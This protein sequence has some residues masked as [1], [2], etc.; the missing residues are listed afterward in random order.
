MKCF[1]MT[2]NGVL[3]SYGTANA[4]WAGYRN[5][6]SMPTASA[7]IGLLGCALGIPKH[8][9]AL[10][11]L[12]DKIVIYY[13]SAPD[14]GQKDQQNNAIDQPVGSDES[15][16]E[17]KIAVPYKLHDYQ[18]ISPRRLGGFGKAKEPDYF[19][20]ANGTKGEQLPIIK[21]YL[22]NSEFTLY[23]A[24]DDS[25][26]RTIHAALLDPKWM[27]YLGR[28]CCIPASPLVCKNLELIDVEDIIGECQCI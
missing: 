18:I 5:T 4:G 9:N 25:V 21:E 20:C 13:K 14:I 23:I 19:I 8:S 7:V 17:K 28:A 10:Q 24:G 12:A 27:V 11:E 2:L 16:T 1:K 6:I 15:K 26:L 3:Q 22:V